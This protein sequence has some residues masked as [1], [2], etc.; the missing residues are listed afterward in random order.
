[1][2]QL[3]K[4]IRSNLDLNQSELARL[5]GVTFATVNRWENGHAVPNRLAQSRLYE[6]C[7]EHSL[8]VYDWVLERIR[9]KSSF[10][11]RSL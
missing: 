5:L 8:P 1:M 9:R 4:E 3:I 2:Q 11:T 7:K 10:R 6:I